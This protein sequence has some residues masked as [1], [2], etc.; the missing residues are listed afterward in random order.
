MEFIDTR[1]VE[2]SPAATLKGVGPAIAQK[3]E[4]LGI[5]NVFDL[6]LHLP[7]R[8]EDRTRVI[9][10]G[11]LQPGDQAVVEGTITLTEVAQ[12]RK[13]MLLCRIQDGSG[14][15]TL[16]FFR[17]SRAQQE[18]L[19]K[20]RALRCFGEVRR[21]A[22]TLEMIHPEYSDIP[23]A[24]ADSLDSYLTP[25]YPA[26]DG[27]TQRKLRDLISTVLKQLEVNPQRLDDHL[28]EAFRSTLPN[29][30][31]TL[32]AVHR[33]SPSVD[34]GDL[35]SHRLPAQR[36]LAYE[37]LLAH[38]LSMR[39]LRASIQAIPAP[40]LSG[41][42]PLRALLSEQLPFALTGAQV[43]VCDEI[44]ADLKLAKPMMRLVQG[45]V[46]SGKT[47]VAAMAALQAIDNGWQVALMAPTELLAEQHARN[48]SEWFA[49]LG[50]EV[51]QLSGR[52][53]G[54][55]R[56]NA[57][58]VIRS[59]KIAVGTH[60]LFQ[61]DVEFDKLGLVIVDE[62]HRF[63]VHQRLALRDKGKATG[64]VPHQLI[65]TATPIPRT[66]SMTAYADLDC[67]IID[68]LPPGRQQINT[69]VIDNV[70]RPE[71]IE[72]VHAACRNGEQCYWVC[73]LVEESDALQAE[74]AEA[75]AE[76]L[77]EALPDLNVGLVH[78]RMKGVDKEHIM[79][80]FKRANLTLLV[81][82]T[83]IEVGVDVPNATLMVI[84][85]AERLGLAQL[86][87]LRGRVGRGSK[88]SAC[89]LTYKAPLGSIAKQRLSVMRQTNDGFQ[90]AEKDLE[91]RGPGEL[92]GTRQ[93]G[94]AEFKIADLE[95][96]AYLLPHVQQDADRLISEFPD[97]ANALTRRWVGASARYAD[98]G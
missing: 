79:G 16:R 77:Q 88:Q 86:H 39:A 15:L 98:V 52:R 95:R 1:N 31:D 45:D 30:H 47:V 43:R 6:L 37:E 44:I 42:S 38:H 67:S 5:R 69:V 20:G 94:V 57:L 40:P 14:S 32:F 9:P 48:F 50:I 73:T 35:R 46:G 96:D 84:E 8:Y 74:A 29:L 33:P 66:L 65:M 23:L 56:E 54:K 25:V 78:G 58:E 75:T 70:R 27:L 3:L 19:K 61:D 53:T 18:A 26:T 76:M 87:Q 17:F 92:M 51:A 21:G 7:I 85:N 2:E 41:D 97:A 12:R 93:T 91:I 49:P 64:L 11:S 90:I 72:R 59:A 10:I 34:S 68:E 22:V 89:V 63:G 81:A 83:V 62:Q 13:R 71:V 4:K 80:E 28:P 36:R 55:A 24:S 82:T 60:A